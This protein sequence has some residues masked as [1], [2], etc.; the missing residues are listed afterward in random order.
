[1]RVGYL[2]DK[3]MK[4]PKNEDAVKVLKDSRFF[5]L[6]DGVGGNKSSE[7]ASTAA[8]DFLADYVYNNPIELVEGSE[9]IFTYFENA[10]NFVNESILQLS[11]TKP[12]YVGMA[13]TLVFAYVDHKILYV[14]NVGDSRVYFIH[15]DEVH[16]ITDDHT[17]VNDLVKMGAIT[18]SEADHHYKKNVITRAIGGNAYN[19]PDCFNIYMEPSDRV[20]ICSDGLYEEVSDSEILDIFNESSDMQDCAERMVERANLNGGN[21][22]VSVICIDMLEESN[23]Q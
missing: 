6:A 13:T 15:K 2:T 7:I 1:M 8:V 18:R 20:L 4:R 21:D 11:N 12:E 5:M 10:V 17:Y 23:E 9:A 22:N 14:G 3:G 16:Q 19:N